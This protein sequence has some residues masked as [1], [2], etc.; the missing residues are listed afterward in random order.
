MFIAA[1]TDPFELTEAASRAFSVKKDVIKNVAK[2]MGKHLCQ[3]LFGLKLVIILKKKHYEL[4]I[5]RDF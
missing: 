3:S 1:I 2:I 5:S 4:W